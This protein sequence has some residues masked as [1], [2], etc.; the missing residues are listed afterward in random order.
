MAGVGLA[1]LALGVNGCLQ[2]PGH[3]VEV[4]LELGYLVGP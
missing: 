2:A 1:E 4:L 3:P